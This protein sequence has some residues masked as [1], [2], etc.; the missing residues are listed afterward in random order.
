[1]DNQHIQKDWKY[2]KNLLKSTDG[3]LTLQMIRKLEKAHIKTVTHLNKITFYKR[4]KQTDVI[5]KGMQIKMTPREKSRTD[6]AKSAH[7]LEIKRLNSELNSS[8]ALVKLLNAQIQN[9]E[10]TL[11]LEIPQLLPSIKIL[12]ANKCERTRIKTKTRHISKI[13]KLTTHLSKRDE[14]EVLRI[15]KVTPKCVENLSSKTLTNAE[16]ATLSMGHNFAIP[17]RDSN[18][19]TLEMIIH[20]EKII[21]GIDT[22]DCSQQRKDT[23]RNEVHHTL[24]TSIQKNDHPKISKWMATSLR[25]LNNDTSI[26]ITKADKGNMAVILDKS[27]YD[28]KMISLINDG[29]YEELQENPIKKY[30]ERVKA[31][32]LDLKHKEKIENSTYDLIR[33]QNEKCPILYGLPKIHKK[34]IPMRPIVDYRYTPG[35]GLSIFLKKMLH[36]IIADHDSTLKNT[37]EFVEKIRDIQLEP[38][39]NMI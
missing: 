9:L 33:P 39:E 6:L 21:S 27:E 2:I 16:L 1:M 31:F 4:C 7:I 35:H 18:K 22:D 30:Q 15:L 14:D 3:L 32:C 17:Q 5:P 26:V 37:Y 19:A 38:M 24:K 25:S 23:V 34:G 13:S 12:I 29:P 10:S 11:Q 28:Q 36:Y 20:V 8:Y